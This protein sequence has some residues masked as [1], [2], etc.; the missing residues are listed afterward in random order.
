MFEFRATKNTQLRD[1][2]GCYI[3]YGIE[4]VERSAGSVIS[5][6][7]IPDVSVSPDEVAELVCRCNQ[8]EL[9]PDQLMDVVEDFIGGEMS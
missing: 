8:C 5:L 1:D 7:H 4:A 9:D 2:I 6:L 3:S